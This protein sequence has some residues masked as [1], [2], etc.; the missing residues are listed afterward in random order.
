MEKEVSKSAKAVIWAMVIIFVLL[1]LGAG[2]I[3]AASKKTRP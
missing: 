1:P 3:L 2:L